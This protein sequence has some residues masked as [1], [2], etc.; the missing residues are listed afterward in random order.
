MS[1]TRCKD[2][3]QMKLDSRDGKISIES[4]LDT[5]FH[6]HD[7]SMY[8]VSCGT[9]GSNVQL[10]AMIVTDIGICVITRPNNISNWMEH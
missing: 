7:T 6:S 8:V 9:Q 3:E 1:S 5:Y 10:D 2:G 4:D